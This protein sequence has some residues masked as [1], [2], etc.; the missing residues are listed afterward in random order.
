MNR[1]SSI[2][3]LSTK[4]KTASKRMATFM[5]PIYNTEIEFYMIWHDIYKTF[6]C[7]KYKTLESFYLPYYGE[8][9]KLK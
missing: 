4:G 9:V 7:F 8:N 5:I 2:F 6:T 3:A 1:L